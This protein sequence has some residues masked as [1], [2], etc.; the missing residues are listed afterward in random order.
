MRD[1]ITWLRGTAENMNSRKDRRGNH[2]EMQSSAIRPNANISLQHQLAVWDAYEI[3]YIWG[4]DKS[5]LW[6]IT[7]MRST[8][9]N[10]H[11]N[12]KK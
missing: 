3:Y 2:S 1:K 11:G 7:E 8:K 5:I 4:N 12:V 10:I 6:A 9:V